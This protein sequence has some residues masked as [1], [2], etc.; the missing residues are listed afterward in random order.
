MLKD[1]LKVVEDLNQ[2][3][4]RD[5]EGVSVI[6]VAELTVSQVTNTISINE[7]AIWDDDGDVNCEFWSDDE[8]NRRPLTSINCLLC[9]AWLRSFE[10]PYMDAIAKL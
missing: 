8:G 5:V 9:W 6:P 4:I 7:Q 2:W 3:F 10:K 1:E